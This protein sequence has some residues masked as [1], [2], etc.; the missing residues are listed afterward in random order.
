MVDSIHFTWTMSC[1][2]TVSVNDGI[3]SL[4]VDAIM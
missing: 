3:V 4:Q 2:V 1:I